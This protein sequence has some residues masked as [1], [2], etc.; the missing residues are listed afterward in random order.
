MDIQNDPMMGLQITTDSPLAPNLLRCYCSWLLFK[1][2]IFMWVFIY[3]TFFP[4]YLNGKNSVEIIW[5][6]QNH[7]YVGSESVLDP[8]GPGR[9]TEID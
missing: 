7:C 3:V 9:T 2:G 1:M 8:Y 6:L 4:P 5:H